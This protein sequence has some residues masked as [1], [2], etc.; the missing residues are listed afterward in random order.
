[1]LLKRYYTIPNPYDTFEQ[2][3]RYMHD[4]LAYM[5]LAEVGRALARLEHCLLFDNNPHPWLQERR[6]ALHLA[7][8]Q[9]EGQPIDAWAYTFHACAECLLP[10]S[11][12]PGHGRN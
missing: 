1:M 3:Q 5:P 2:C 6:E 8:D 7:L 9:H 12:C 10:A 4:D 11:Q